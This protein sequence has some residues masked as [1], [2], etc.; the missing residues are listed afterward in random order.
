M[1]PAGLPWSAE[2]QRL[3]AA[4]GY[5][6]YALRGP[7][8]EPDGAA[9]APAPAVAVDAIDFD[10]PLFPA[11][12]RAAGLLPA[13]PSEFDWQG[14]AHAVGLPPLAELRRDPQAKRALWPRLRRWRRERARR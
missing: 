13:R 8:G 7:V 2:Q 14:W 12:I 9:T 6:L 11:L 10:D 5:A 4:M 1:S 3:L